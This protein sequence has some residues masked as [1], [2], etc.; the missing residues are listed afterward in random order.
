MCNRN[1]HSLSLYPS[2]QL[3]HPYMSESIPCNILLN[4]FKVT[5][6]TGISHSVSFSCFFPFFFAISL[7]LSCIHT[8]TLTSFEEPTKISMLHFLCRF[9][10]FV[11]LIKAEFR[12]QCKHTYT[13]TFTHIYIGIFYI[14]PL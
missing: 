6:E 12:N 14:H 13:L 9:C 11:Q 10:S 7:S 3:T 2:F 5:F 1:F 4:E 8:R